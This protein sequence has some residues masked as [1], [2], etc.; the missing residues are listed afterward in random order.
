MATV[1]VTVLNAQQL[2]FPDGHVETRSSTPMHGPKDPGMT[3]HPALGKF[4]SAAKMDTQF[5]DEVEE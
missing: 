4:V 2:K 3:W 5:E 1:K